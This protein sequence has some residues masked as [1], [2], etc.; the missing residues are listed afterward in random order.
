MAIFGILSYILKQEWA[1][2]NLQSF[3]IILTI[4][5][6]NSK[7]LIIQSINKNNIKIKLN[8]KTKYEGVEDFIMTELKRFALVKV[9][10]SFPRR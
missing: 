6:E 4:Q 3:H 2:S 8:K 5:S 7:Y 1:I 10:V 9:V